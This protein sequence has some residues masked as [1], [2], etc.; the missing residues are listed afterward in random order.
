[1]NLKYGDVLWAW[2]WY[3]RY[4]V[5]KKIYYRFRI[6]PIPFWYYSGLNKG[7]RPFTYPRGYKQKQMVDYQWLSYD[8]DFA[9]PIIYKNAKWQDIWDSDP[10]GEFEYYKYKTRSDRSWKKTK[11][12]KQ[13]M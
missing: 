1:M 9:E 8:E 4:P 3:Y 11:K 12:R 6:D 13:W 7:G 5:K 10:W 2:A